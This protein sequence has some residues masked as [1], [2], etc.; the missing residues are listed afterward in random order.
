ME[1]NPENRAQS[2]QAFVKVTYSHEKKTSCDKEQGSR[3]RRCEKRES[4]LAQ[5]DD[6][7]CESCRDHT[8]DSEM[9]FFSTIH[10]FGVC[11]FL[12]ESDTRGIVRLDPRALRREPALQS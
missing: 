3:R 9:L 8:I 1:T 10:F 5:S 6:V 7:D 2:N 11:L 4:C 12:E